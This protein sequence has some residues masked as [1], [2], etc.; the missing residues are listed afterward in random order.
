MKPAAYSWIGC[1]GRRGR[2]SL[3]V[4]LVLYSS[5]AAAGGWFDRQEADDGIEPR[6]V[7]DIHYGEVLF[8][9]YSREYFS[10]ITR[11][12]AAQQLERMPNHV[13]DAELLL[14]G[15][16]LSYGMHTEAGRIFRELL[17]D[18]TREEVRNQAWYYLGKI[19]FQRGYPGEAE[20]ALTRAQGELPIELKGDRQLL[21]SQVLMA[22]GRNEAAAELL[23]EWEGP[24]SWRPY[25]DYNHGVA[26]LRRGDLEASRRSLDALGRIKADREETWALKDKANL[27]LG[28]ALLRDEESA[29]ARRYLER[30]RL[31]G[32]YSNLA[33]LGT[34]WADAQAGR[35]E[36]ALVPWTELYQRRTIEPAVQ[37]AMLALPYAYSNLKRYGKA[38]NLYEDALQKYGEEMAKLDIAIQSIEDGVLVGALVDNSPDLQMS[39]FWYLKTLPEQASESIYLEE[40]IAGHDFQEGLKNYRDLEFLQANLQGWAT[41]LGAFKEMIEARRARYAEQLPRAQA[42]LQAVDV[43]GMRQRRDRL[44][45]QLEEARTSGNPLAIA[46]ARE[47]EQWD[48]LKSI[49][50]RLTDIEEDTPGVRA[51]RSKYQLLSGTLLWQVNDRYPQRLWEARKRLQELDAEIKQTGESQASLRKAIVDAPKTFEGFDSRL[52]SLRAEILRMQPQVDF[53]LNDQSLFLQQIAISE[54]ERRKTILGGYRSQ[55]RFALAQTW[56]QAAAKNVPAPTG[57]PELLPVQPDDAADGQPDPEAEEPV[58]DDIQFDESAAPAESDT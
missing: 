35:F 15:M 11:L 37:E 1:A 27:A 9:F 54:L 53:A 17:D 28:Y 55:A 31:A 57:Q 32:P 39:W 40:L 2:L 46:T 22:D 33:L 58:L 41:S 20:E 25:A 24:E 16:D 29:Q 8:H 44:S 19:S 50:E 18:N 34:G 13:K 45:A 52:A 23:T 36:R 5:V 49:G 56:D 12:L 30:V 21:L 14:G 48:K 10:S 6:P 7:E 38:A 26:H 42:A 4:A 3:F 51:A 47:L 43:E